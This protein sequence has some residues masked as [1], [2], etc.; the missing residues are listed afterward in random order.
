MEF[1]V[2]RFLTVGVDFLLA[3]AFSAL[4]IFQPDFE[5]RVYKDV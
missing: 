5:G 3:A 4:K 2:N 1:Q